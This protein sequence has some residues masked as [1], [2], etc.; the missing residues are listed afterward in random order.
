MDLCSLF[1][2]NHIF[3]VL[4]VESHADR[5]KF[6]HPSPIIAVRVYVSF[7]APHG[8]NPDLNKLPMK[9]FA[10]CINSE[11]FFFWTNNIFLVLCVESHADREKF[12]HPSP[13]IAV[14]VYVSFMA[15]HGSNPDLNK[16]PIKKND[17]HLPQNTLEHFINFSR[18][19]VLL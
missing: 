13:I 12:I 14:R 5:E 19:K 3:L 8:S 4:C 10:W 15:P 7:M 18:F 11:C 2:T 6:I 9:I 1:W 17:T 16:L